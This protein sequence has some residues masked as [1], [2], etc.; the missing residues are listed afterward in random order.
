MDT[1]KT[2]QAILRE[3]LKPN[4]LF[5]N[6]KLTVKEELLYIIS[7]RT[8]LELDLFTSIK[9]RHTGDVVPSNRANV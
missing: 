9:G 1:L 6:G 5:K 4:E 3:R 2:V 8:K 7:A